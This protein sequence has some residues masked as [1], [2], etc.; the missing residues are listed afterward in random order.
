MITRPIPG[1]PFNVASDDGRIFSLDREVNGRV[2]RG[3]ELAQ[4]DR[5]KVVRKGRKVERIATGYRSVTLA[6]EG[7]SRTEYVHALVMLAFVGPRPSDEH[8]VLHGDGVRHHNALSNLRYGTVVE[9]AADRETH[10][11]AVRG[12][13]HGRS[14]HSLETIREIKRRLAGGEKACAIA[15]ALNVN[16][17]TVYQI[18]DG[19]QWSHVAA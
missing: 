13:T 2:I 19:K 9:N 18:R 14:K 5:M 16:N 1:W 17:G 7:R 8:E 3:R 10:G 15:R 6:C 4:F 11:T 12:E